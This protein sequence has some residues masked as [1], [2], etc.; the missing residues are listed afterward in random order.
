MNF[1]SRKELQAYFDEFVSE[2]QSAVVKVCS[3]SNS[4]STYTPVV[5]MLDMP[6]SIIFENGKA[7]VIEYYNVCNIYVEYRELT[8]SEKEELSKI[9][10]NDF[11][12]VVYDIYDYN[13]TRISKR[14]TL[15]ME[16]DVIE[17]VDVC[18]FE[19]DYDKWEN[20]VIVTKEGTEENFG[21][22]ILR[23]KNGKTIH[24]LA[25]PADSDGYFDVWASTDYENIKV[26]NIE[27]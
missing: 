12:N 25:Q 8:D 1:K 5:Y 2:N 7:L 10:N 22:I 21:E 9:Y 26:F 16:Y 18:Y 17:K 20:G 4:S 14:I 23:M 15:N 6:L 13:T 11:F 3:P 24:I 27:E 19:G